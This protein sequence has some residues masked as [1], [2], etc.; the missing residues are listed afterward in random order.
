LAQAI[1]LGFAGGIASEEAANLIV[2]K[3][4]AGVLNA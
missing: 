4:G 2:E 1:Q 3:I